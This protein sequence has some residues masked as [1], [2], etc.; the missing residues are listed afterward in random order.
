MVRISSASVLI[1]LAA[2][3]AQGQISITAQTRTVEAVAGNGS[4]SHFIESS[5]FNDWD[6][7]AHKLWIVGWNEVRQTSSMTPWTLDCQMVGENAGN[8]DGVAGSVSS[9][10]RVDFSINQPMDVYAQGTWTGDDLSG[11]TMRMWNRSTNGNILGPGDS[12][13]HLAPG[14]YAYEQNYFRSSRGVFDGTMA[15]QFRPG[16][17]QCQYATVVTNRWYTGTTTTASGSGD[18]P[19]SCNSPAFPNA[20]WFKYTAPRSGPLTIS[21]CGS[22][23]DTVLTVFNN[24]A[25][26]LAA[27]NIVVCNDDVPAGSSC[28]AG[29]NASFVTVNVL[30]GQQFLIRLSGYNN[31]AGDYRLNVGPVNDNCN[32]MIPATLGDNAFDNRLADTDGAV[33]N[34]CV[35]GGDNQINGDLWYSFVPA[36]SGLLTLDTCGSSFDTKLVI[37]DGYSCGASGYMACSDDSA[38]CGGNNLRSKITDL[39]V[40]AGH[41]YTIR[42]GG[43]SNNRGAGNLRLSMPPA[44]TADFNQDSVVDF[45]DYLDFVSAFSAS[46]PAADFND[47]SVIDFFDYL[48]FVDSFAGGC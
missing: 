16:N 23:F 18:G 24:G 20:V 13:Q 28:G 2:G 39:P 4:G 6:G 31:A 46:E 30:S 48:D 38:T 36:T 41:N 45:F 7:Y 3:L 21:T 19:A 10:Y 8:N 14:N 17:D 37:Y 44:C 12:Y 34:S 33:V 35:F 5:N 43:F 47:D 26:N 1:V 22:S 9:R 11:A 15:I 25:C 40:V 27:G 29:T 42:V 32:S